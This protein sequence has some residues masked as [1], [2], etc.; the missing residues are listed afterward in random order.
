MEIRP[1]KIED[2][3]DLRMTDCF[4]KLFRKNVNTVYSSTA[5]KDGKVIFCTGGTPLWKG[6][7]EIWM[8]VVDRSNPTGIVLAARKIMIDTIAKHRLTRIQA[9][10]RADNPQARRFMGLLGFKCETPDGL[11]KFNEDGTD[12]YMYSLVV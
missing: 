7:L 8:S 12:S 3:D 1:F 11:R 10:V 5:T 6:V 2:V 9:V 4:A